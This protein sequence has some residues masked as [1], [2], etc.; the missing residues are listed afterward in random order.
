LMSNEM[1]ATGA[2]QDQKDKLFDVFIMPGVSSQKWLN[3]LTN[4]NARL[5]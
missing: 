1:V 2:G 4:N 5:L 3:Y